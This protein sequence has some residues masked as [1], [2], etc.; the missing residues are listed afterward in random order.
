VIDPIHYPVLF[1]TAL[2]AGFV[3]AI[4]G[5]GGLITIP[6]LLNLGLPP[7]LALGTNKL[8]ASFGSGS[9]AWHYAR[10]GLVDVRACWAG[11]ICSFVG[12]VFGT[13]AVQCLS[14][15]LLQRGLPWLL[16]GI[17]LYLLLQPRAG[18]APG[19]ARLQPATFYFLFGL[20]IGFY[21]G[22]FG[23]GTGTFWTMAL[24]LWLGYDLTRATAHTKLFNFASNIASL[25]AFLLAGNV[26]FAAG[27]VMAAGQ[28]AG[29]WLGAHCVITRGT[30]L[31][32]PVFLTM[33]LAL[34]AKL[35]WQ[36]WRT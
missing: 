6:V 14:Q 26:L 29:S 18:T 5:G 35:L 4:A 30:A 33:V 15:A 36:S 31:V 24:I 10:A 22:F 27:L 13:L 23:P 16:A 20:A 7:Q 25:A 34:I 9:A 3:D 17:A 28:L 19:R 21:D 8:Q 32:R 1:L 11:V 2:A 12:A